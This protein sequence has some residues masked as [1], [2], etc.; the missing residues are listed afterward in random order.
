VRYI[1]SEIITV[2]SV[3]LGMT[4]TFFY[5]VQ[6]TGSWLEIGQSITFFCV[7]SLLLLWSAGICA[8]GEYLMSDVIPSKQAV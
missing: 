7:S 8:A 4:L 3:N 5:M 1:D 2:Q 6:D